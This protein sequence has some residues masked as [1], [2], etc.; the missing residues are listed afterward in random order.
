MGFSIDIRNLI[1]YLYLRKSEKVKAFGCIWVSNFENKKKVLN[2]S[3]LFCKA[4][5]GCWGLVKCPARGYTCHDIL[6]QGAV[7]A[8]S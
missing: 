5:F 4:V 1:E 7:M 8:Y 2:Y 6:L 3:R